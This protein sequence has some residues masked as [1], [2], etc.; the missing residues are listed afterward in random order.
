M[1]WN[2]IKL[3][4]T[5][6]VRDQLRDRRTLF[7]MAVLPL[8]LYPLL[9]MS[10]FQVAQFIREQPTRVLVI[11]R[12]GLPTVPSLVEGDHFAER[13]FAEPDKLRL[14]ELHF[15]E[16]SDLAG[17]HDLKPEA[18]A[19]AAVEQGEYEAVVYVPPDFAS[20]LDAFRAAL[21]EQA[22][23]P[24]SGAGDHASGVPSPAIFYNT[25]KEKSQL[26][27]LRI[28]RVLDS[29]TDEIIRQNL[30]SS[31]FPESAV[32]PFDLHEHDVAEPSEREA[33]VW[34]KI[35]PFLLLVWA[36]TGAF[37]PAVDLCAGEKERGTLETL[38][39]SPAER[40]E[41][42]WGKLLTVMLFSVATAV[43]NILSMGLT[44]SVV[45]GQFPEIGAP[46]PSAPIWL[47]AALL[48]MSALFS[49]LCLALA[50]FARS[51]KEGQYYLMPLLLVTMPLVVLPMAPGVELNLG[52]SLIPV[53]GVMLLLR[54]MLE[55]NYLLALQFAAPVVVVTLACCMFAIRWAVDQFNSESVLFRES[56]RLDFGLWLK[57]LLRDREATPTVSGAVFCGVLILMVR[58]FMGFALPSPDSFNQLVSITVVTQLVVIGTPALLMTIMFT[59]SPA[60]TLLLRRPPWAAVPMALA[61]AVVLHPFAQA[62]NRLVQVLYP[63]NRQVREQ[64][65]SMLASGAD[66]P[67]QM[68]LVLA[69]VPAIFEELAF[70]GFILSGFRHLG[71][72][73]RAIVMSA[74]FFG[75]AHAVLQQSI[76]AA[77]LGVL[78]GFLAVQTGSVLPGIVFHV[79]HNAIALFSPQ[80][81]E[82]S[83]ARWPWLEGLLGTGPD[84]IAYHPALMFSAGLAAMLILYWFHRL[85][86]TR[87]SEE[88]LQETIDLRTQHALAG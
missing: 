64:L 74:L 40:I 43:L 16:D 49:A 15:A 55:G 21:V 76:V 29:W 6:E 47:L 32:R 18:W 57:H 78:L 25:A 38:L 79:A 56:E 83:L 60:A 81:V 63:V 7:M 31:H 4:F 75:I 50:A 66:A 68:L 88:S 42:V 61:L 77:V 70:R 20:R 41:I 69:I 19:R 86:Y 62:V 1:N 67:W 85:A 51:S 34:S 24:G 71:H 9:G 13:L 11:G 87:S 54:A 14:L 17:Q 27:Y 28:S 80:C 48:P 26:A 59:A 39:S 65:E 45:L 58:F 36:L 72:K 53:A 2:N 12:S 30:A 35:L 23:S 37:Y 10:L 5:R 46:P 82:G 33:V 73:W 3:I 52:N 84:G 8:L 22:R 44:G